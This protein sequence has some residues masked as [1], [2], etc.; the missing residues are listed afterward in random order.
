MVYNEREGDKEHIRMQFGRLE[1]LS[2]GA[3]ANL[4]KIFR[5]GRYARKHKYVPIATRIVPVNE[6]TNEELLVDYIRQEFDADGTWII[7][8]WDRWKKNKHFKKHFLCTW[9]KCKYFEGCRVK[10]RKRINPDKYQACKLNPKTRANWSAR[11]R[12]TIKMKDSYGEGEDDY[13]YTISRKHN[14]M[15]R[16][17]NWFWQSNKEVKQQREGDTYY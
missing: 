2:D 6:I 3:R 11:F 13:S 16:F 10:K 5:Q 15:N 7:T 9:T 17:S 12:V 14:L 8:V 4:P 1:P